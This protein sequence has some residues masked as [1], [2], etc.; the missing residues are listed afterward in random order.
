L[1]R[2]STERAADALSG[3]RAE[4][5]RPSAG[6]ER[7]QSSRDSEEAENLALP[8]EEVPEPGRD[9]DSSEEAEEEEEAEEAESSEEA[10][11]EEEAEVEEEVEEELHG[12]GLDSEDSTSEVPEESETSADKDKDALN[13][14]E[15]EPN[16]SSAHGPEPGEV[17]ESSEDSTKVP[18]DALSGELERTPRESAGEEL[19]RSSKDSEEARECA[20]S[21]ER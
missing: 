18:T 16:S 15:V 1:S 7:H 6:A 20:S 5:T 14:K 17:L 9:A 11:E 8:T 19:H 10:E 12:A 4:P 3:E 2:D 13:S 21:S